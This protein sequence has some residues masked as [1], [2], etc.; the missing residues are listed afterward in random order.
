MKLKSA[1]PWGFES[2]LLKHIHFILPKH[3]QEKSS[4]ISAPGAWM[5]KYAFTDADSSSSVF[6]SDR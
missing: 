1:F 2:L 4:D 3:P 6:W 5:P